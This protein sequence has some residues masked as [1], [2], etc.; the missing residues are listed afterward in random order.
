MT[1]ITGFKH[2]TVEGINDC[3]ALFFNEGTIGIMHDVPHDV[4]NNC[5]LQ[6][7]DNLHV[8]VSS[9]VGEEIHEELLLARILLLMCIAI[10]NDS[11]YCCLDHNHIGTNPCNCG[12]SSYSITNIKI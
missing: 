10:N 9:P 2:I 7:D 11:G 5:L 4:I 6:T 1:K 12:S 3:I 8:L